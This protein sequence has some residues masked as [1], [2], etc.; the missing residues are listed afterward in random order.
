MVWLLTSTYTPNH[1]T[2][3]DRWEKLAGSE[4]SCLLERRHSEM[5]DLKLEE[6]SGE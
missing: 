4:G 6:V 5:T 1:F 3:T 2:P